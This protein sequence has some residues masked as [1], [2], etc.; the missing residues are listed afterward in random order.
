M[1]LVLS[2]S[3]FHLSPQGLSNAL[4]F[5][6]TLIGFGR[7]QFQTCLRFFQWSGETSQELLRGLPNR[8]IR[9][10]KYKGPLRVINDAEDR[11]NI[12]KGR[13]STGLREVS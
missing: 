3:S 11:K 12:S 5:L 10:S 6:S 13:G 8:S 7:G 2:I 9:S 1:S 4:G